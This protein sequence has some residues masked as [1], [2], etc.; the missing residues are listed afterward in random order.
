MLINLFITDKSS[1]V[2]QYFSDSRSFINKNLKM[3]DSSRKLPRVGNNLF[4]G[5]RLEVIHSAECSHR[6][7][8]G[9]IVISA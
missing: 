7:L 2:L 5:N 8:V 1:K 3:E 6:G 9:I 4:K